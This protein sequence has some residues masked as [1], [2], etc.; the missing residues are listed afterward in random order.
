MLLKKKNFKEKS[1]KT[2]QDLLVQVGRG[3]FYKF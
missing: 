2:K 1:S 3:Q